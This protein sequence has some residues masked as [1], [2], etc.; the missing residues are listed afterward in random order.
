MQIPSHSNCPRKGWKTA[1]PDTC[2]LLMCVRRPRITPTTV[3]TGSTNSATRFMYGRPQGS[4]PCSLRLR[5]G[6]SSSRPPRP[7]PGMQSGG[8]ECC[9]L[10]G[11]YHSR[12]HSA[13]YVK[14][15]ALSAPTRHTLRQTVHPI[16]LLFRAFLPGSE[17]RVPS[18]RNIWY[19][20]AWMD[21]MPSNPKALHAH[22]LIRDP[23]SQIYTWLFPCSFS[24]PG[25]G[26]TVPSLS[27]V[28]YVKAWT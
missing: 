13:K 16:T 25:T 7:P 8:W 23:R 18:G 3:Q 27:Y 28:W 20:K 14:C 17:R 1:Q 15:I 24:L 26:R 21:V 12:L 2:S 19:A 5:Q 9:V 4:I 10:V 22:A 6:S 11:P